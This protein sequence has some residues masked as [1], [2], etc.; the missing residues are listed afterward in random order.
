VHARASLPRALAHPP[1]IRTLSRAVPKAGWRGAGNG[2]PKAGWD[3]ECLFKLS[4]PG[5]GF[6]DIPGLDGVV[7]SEAESGMKAP[8]GRYHRSP[9]GLTAGRRSAGGVRN[10]LIPTPLGRTSSLG[11]FF[12]IF[13]LT[14]FG[15]VSRTRAPDADGAA[16]RGSRRGVGDQSEGRAT[17]G[18]GPKR[19]ALTGGLSGRRGGP[20]VPAE[21]FGGPGVP[22]CGLTGLRVGVLFDWPTLSACCLTL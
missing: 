3:A 20:G 11:R 15:C 1:D 7:R 13:L 14:G 18:A 6:C 5:Q 2:G 22:V 21:S 10:R 17:R 4:G 16:Q 19:Q 12:L 9:G 8:A